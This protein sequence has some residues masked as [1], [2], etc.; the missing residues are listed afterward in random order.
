M[1]A[2]LFLPVMC[3]VMLL[4]ACASPNGSMS[5]PDLLGDPAPVAAAMR[6][7]VI[8]PGTKSVS[9]TGGETVQFVIGEKSFGWNFDVVSYV[10]PFDLN[11]IAPSNMLDHKVLVYIAPNPLYIGHAGRS[12]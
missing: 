9:V 4:A 12:M 5:R 3:T 6:T 11:Q 10:F 7:I 8:A 1:N 2:R